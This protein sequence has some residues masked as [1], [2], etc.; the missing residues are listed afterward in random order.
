MYEWS[1]N[2]SQFSDTLAKCSQIQERIALNGGLRNDFN[3]AITKLLLANHG[4]S[5][6]QALDHT[7]SDQ[8]MTPNVV[9]LPAKDAE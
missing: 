2:H 5:D 9:V 4:Y 6:K 8:S 3:A 7:S 1:E